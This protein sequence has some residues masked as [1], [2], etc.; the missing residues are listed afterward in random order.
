MSGL[1][2]S[3]ILLGPMQIGSLM[4]AFWKYVLISQ[5]NL[6]EKVTAKGVDLARIILE[7]SKQ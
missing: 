3:Q 5:Q 2:Y 1:H 6:V 7:L 4:S